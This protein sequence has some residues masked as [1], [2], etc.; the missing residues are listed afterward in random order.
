MSKQ[1]QIINILKINPFISQKELAQL[2]GLSRPAVA[3]Y[4]AK[5]TKEG[6]IKG[7]AYILQEDTILCLGAA[8]ID[9]EART[10]EEIQYKI[11]NPVEITESLGGVARNFA[12]SLHR[13]GMKTSLLTAIGNDS[14]GEQLLKQT[15]AEGIEMNHVWTFPNERTGTFTMITNEKGENVLA[16]ADMSIYEK[17]TPEMIDDKWPYI[18]SAKAVFLDTNFTKE[19]LH[20]LLNRLKEQNIPIYIDAVSPIK[21]KKLPKDLTN[22][23]LLTLSP[24]DVEEGQS[25]INKTKQIMESGA[26]N[27]LILGRNQVTFKE[28]KKIETIDYQK[29]FKINTDKQRNEIAALI[30]YYLLKNKPLKRAIEKALASYNKKN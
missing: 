8:N 21:M 28:G 12:S 18:Q 15:I 10:L 6:I 22:V 16:I 13:L 2:V 26:K 29:N 24:K 19:V 11:S 30:M 17:I 7:R 27:I 25:P 14:S 3:N 5:L 9:Q 4:I 20:H 1:E 23:Q